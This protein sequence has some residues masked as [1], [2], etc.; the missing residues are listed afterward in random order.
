VLSGRKPGLS[1]VL[2]G[3]GTAR[4]V[5]VPLIP[6]FALARTHNVTTALAVTPRSLEGDG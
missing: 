4:Q 5:T 2:K 6:W 1:A 3:S